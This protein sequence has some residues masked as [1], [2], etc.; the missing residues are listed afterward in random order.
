MARSSAGRG[1]GEG[2]GRVQDG[3][4]AYTRKLTWNCCRKL[5]AKK[6]VE[7]MGSALSLTRVS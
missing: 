6:Q 3:G 5:L 4:R 1:G 7:C 2:G